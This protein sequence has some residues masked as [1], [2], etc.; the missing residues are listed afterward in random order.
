MGR[1]KSQAN[2]EKKKDEGKIFYSRVNDSTLF[3]SRD[4]WRFFFCFS[5]IA[6]LTFSTCLHRYRCQQRPRYPDFYPKKTGD[7]GCA[8][9][10]SIASKWLRGVVKSR[11]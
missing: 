9:S 6:D 3:A 11:V 7:L 2:E 8:A 5:L 10:I 1:G 4:L